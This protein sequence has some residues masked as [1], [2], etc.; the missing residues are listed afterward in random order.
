MDYAATYARFVAD[1]QG[2]EG[3][4]LATGG[5]VERHHI[6]PKSLGGSDEQ[7]NLLVLTPEDHFFAHLLLAKIHGGG[8]WWPLMMM[9][10]VAPTRWGMSAAKAAKMRN[11]YAAARRALSR[12]GNN[13]FNA[14]I[15]DWTNLDTGETVS[16]CI[17]DMHKLMG[18]S[19]STWTSV[20]SGARKSMRGWTIRPDEIRVRGLKGKIFDFVSRD[21]RMFRGT[22]GEFCEMA[23]LP[24]ASGT[25]VV[26]YRS[27]SRCGWRLEG[28]EDRSH[29]APKD[30]TRPGKGAKIITLER[31]GERLVGD[32]VEIARR[33][34]TTVASVSASVY[35][36]RTGKSQT[37]KGYCLST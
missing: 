5:Y 18:G 30:G 14:T 35:S 24:P 7:A 34:G 9:A 8:M 17:Y 36:L 23:G 20:V 26:R 6:Q 33:L 4:L 37:F 2:K 29:N 3:A 25:R 11:H 21:G 13:L 10:S 32:R 28:V 15:Y 16:A 27:V 1:R 12:E 19:R 31:D 22:Q